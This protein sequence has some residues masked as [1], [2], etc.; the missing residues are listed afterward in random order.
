MGMS[1]IVEHAIY[2]LNLLAENV[3]VGKKVV[4]SDIRKLSARLYKEISDKTI[5]NVLF[6]CEELLEEHSWGSGVIAFDW[7]Y[8]VRTQYTEATYETFYS[9]LKKYVR[10]WGTCDDFCTHAFGEL[11]RRYKTLFPKIK[12]WTKDEDFWVRRASAVILIPAILHNDYQG[13]EPLTISDLLMYDKHDLVQKGYGWMLKSLSQV[14][15]DSV[16]DYL[17]DN[18][19]RMP[20][21]AYRYALEKYDKETRKKLMSL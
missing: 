6:L 21:T 1:L 12:S 3:P 15:V 20:R 10:G 19:G 13:I 9:W 18:H 5:D 16:T 7:A 2:E 14:D 8:R 17:I 11:L 4:T